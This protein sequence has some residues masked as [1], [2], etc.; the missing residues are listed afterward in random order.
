GAAVNGDH[1][2]A[3]SFAA[4]RQLSRVYCPRIPAKPHLEGDRNLRCS[5]SRLDQPRCVVEIAHQRRTRIAARD[6]LRRTSHIDINEFGAKV[7]RAAR[8]LRHPAS[9]PPGE[10]YDERGNAI[11]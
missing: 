2:D 5:D 9:F 4:S 10:L 3:G 7:L 6:L 1:L 8:T 11:T